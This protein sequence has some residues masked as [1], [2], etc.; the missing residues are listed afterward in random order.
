[1]TLVHSKSIL[2]YI[3]DSYYHPSTFPFRTN[4]EDLSIWVKELKTIVG[5]LSLTHRLCV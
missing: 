1:M 2:V 5:S 4:T 3:N